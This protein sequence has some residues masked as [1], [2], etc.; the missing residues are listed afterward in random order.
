MMQ[1][2]R[3]TMT[4]EGFVCAVCGE[5]ADR[6]GVTARDHCPR[7]LSSLHLDNNPGDR[8][9]D[10]GAVLEPI[11]IRK[12]KKSLQI[13]YRC[14]GCGAIKKNKIADDDDAE[15]IIALSGEPLPLAAKHAR[16]VLDDYL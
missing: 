9:A 4:D 15:L 11:G 10:C 5:S 1:K 6:L 3:F 8:S 14:K 12:G 7:C 16:G 2:K 13:V